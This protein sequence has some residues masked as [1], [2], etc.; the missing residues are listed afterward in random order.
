M[1]PGYVYFWEA[2]FSD[3]KNLKMIGNNI[4]HRE[5]QYDLAKKVV[6]NIVLFHI[7]YLACEMRI[8]KTIIALLAAKSLNKKSIL[9][10]TKKKAISSIQGDYEKIGF[11][12]DVNF[13]CTNFEQ[14][15]EQHTKGGWDLI[16]V[17]EASCL[18]QFPKPAE[19]TK[20]LRLICVQLDVIYLSGTPTP[21]SWS[22]IYHQLWISSFSPFYEYN[23]FYKWAKDYVDVHIK[24][25]STHTINDY[26][27]ADQKKI[28][29]K[30]NHFFITYSQ[31]D[32][33]FKQPDVVDVIKYIPMS[34]GKQY[35][36]DTLKK[37]RIVY[38]KHGDIIL[39]DSGVKLM[40]KIHQ[41]CT[42]TVIAEPEPMKEG[43]TKENPAKYIS[44][45]DSKARYIKENYVNKK[46]AIYYVFQSEKTQ[47]EWNF[48]GQITEDPIEFNHSTDK[49]FISQVQSGARGI[50]LET[51]DYIIMYNIH[52][53]N[54]IYWQVRARLQSMHRSDPP[55]VHWI[56]TKGGIEDKI[57][58][59]VINKQDYYLGYFMKDFFSGGIEFKEEKQIEI[60][61][62]SAKEKFR[63]SLKKI[64][65]KLT[66]K[67]LKENKFE[68]A[69]NGQLFWKAPDG[70][71]TIYA[72]TFGQLQNKVN[73]WKFVNKKL[74]EG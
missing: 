42:G 1:P 20:L 18:G 64:I 31:K 14:L 74:L 72:D 22:Q 41:I 59:R 70:K 15:S 8:G 37:D 46:I 67:T 73:L 51:C 3:F 11:D 21:E 36:I 55:E 60:P 43:Q 66:E 68:K 58:K 63:Q 35:L 6:N 33:G 53:S 38:G 50:N 56:F 69:D 2:I 47:L 27:D 24:H 28:W 54:E 32:A 29:E 26:S 57:Y 19:R 49:I 71:L 16:I 7:C 44:F 30:I 12:Y 62:S 52:F 10:I 9:F 40:G 23:T 17:D 34:E 65:D 39:A 5:Y 45:E 13:L 61:D 25:I 4:E 48:A